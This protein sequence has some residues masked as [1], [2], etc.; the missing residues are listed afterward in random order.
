MSRTT[1]P[2]LGRLAPEVPPWRPQETT[3]R[4]P[5]RLRCVHRW[6]EAQ[7][8]RAPESIAVAVAVAGGGE[9]LT[10]SRLN[11]RANRLARRLRAMG[12]GPEILVGLYASRSAD[13][14]A[15]LLAVLKAG[16]AYVPLD[17]AY[18]EERIA[19]MLGD[20]G[21]AVL[22]TEDRL[23]DRVSGFDGP[24][25]SL[26]GDRESY[27]SLPSTDLTGGPVLDNLAYVIYT[28]G[29]TGR[30]KGAMIPHRG[31]A[32]YLAWC[33]RAYA[34][35]QGEGAPVHSS[36]SFDLTVTSLLAP[37]VAGRRVDLLDEDLGIEQLTAA[38]RSRRNYSLV[39]ITPAHLRSLGD[40]L[41]AD[42]LAGR[43]RAF[44]IGGEPL[45]AEHVAAWRRHA[46]GTE[47]VNE[48]GPTETVV[49]CCV[50]RVPPEGSI[51]GSLPIGRP[52]AGLRLYVLDRRL[53]PVPVGVAGELHIGGAGV[54]RGYLKRP[55]LTADRFLPDPFGREPGA[56]MYR[57]GDLARW[58]PDGNLEYLGRVDRQVKIRGH[59]VEPDEVEDALVRHPSVR[60]AAVEPR[61]YGPDD[62]RLFAYVTPTPDGPRPEPA[63]LRRFLKGTLPEPMIPSAFVVLDALPLTPNGKV[64]RA[65]LPAPAHDQRS[66]ETVFVAPRGPFE[67]LV[68]EVWSAVLGVKRV[69]ALD[70]FFDLGGHSLLATQVMS[71]IRDTFGFDVP[72]REL[73]ANPTVAALSTQIAERTR[74]G[75]G[76]DVTPPRPPGHDGPIPASHAQ[77]SLWFL[78]QLAPGEPTFHITLSSR[79][80]GPLDLEI[81][82]RAFAEI[83]RRHEV[84]RTTFR[85]DDGRP[86]QVI[87]EAMD[88]PLTTVDLRDLAPGAR[89]AEARRL[90]RGQAL[91][92]FDLERGPLARVLVLILGDDDHGIVLTMHHIV[93]DGWSLDVAARELVALYDAFGRGG[94]SPLEPLPIQYADYAVWQRTRLAGDDAAPLRD[95]WTRQ[96]AGVAPLELPTDRPRPPIRTSR[97][98]FHPLAIPAGLAGSI[99]ALG[100]R[101]G[102]TPFMVLLAAWQALLHRYSGQHDIVVGSPIA[103]R[104]RSELEGLIGYFV[105]M[106]AL[107]ADFSDDPSGLE[108]VGR[109]RDVALAAYEHQ[110]LPLELVIDAINPPRDPSRTPLFQVMFVLQ[111][112]RVPDLGGA[113]LTFEPLGDE[114]G[115][116]T[117]KFDLSLTLEESPEGFAGGIE[118]NTDLFDGETV[119]RMAARFLVLLRGLVESPDRRVSRLPLLSDDERRTTLAMGVGEPG[120]AADEFVAIHRHFE[121]Q[122]DRTP[123][124]RAV[125]SGG[126]C[127]TYRQLD[128]RANRLARELSARGI[129]RGDRVAIGMN[130]SVGLAVGLLGTLKAGAT[131][132]PLDPDYPGDRIA[133]M[134]E[135]AGAGLLLTQE[136]LAGRWPATR[137]DLLRIDADWP[138][139][140][141]QSSSRPVGD[142]NGDDSA[143]VIYT[144]GTTGEPRGVIVS[145]GGLVNH[146]L[147]AASLF[148]LSPDDR[149][150]QFSSLSF[151][152]AIE[153]MF[154][155]WISGAAVVF[156]DDS[157]L[158]GPLEFSQ[159]SARERITVLDLPTVYWHA[160][161]EG[162]ARLGERLPE[163]LRL[164]IVGG[165]R[166]SPR[167]FAEWRQIGGDRV[168]W[169]NTYGPTEGTVIASAFEPTD[170]QSEERA[171]PELPI[172]RPIP[173]ARIYLLD[174]RMEPVPA[175]LPGE[176]YIGGEGVALGYLGRP[177]ATASRFVP[178]P[179]GAVPGARLFRTGDRA[180]WRPDGQLEFVG[181]VDHQVKIRG[182]RVEP[183]EVESVLRRHPSVSDAVVAAREDAAG[184]RRLVAHVVPRPP[185]AIDPDDLRRWLQSTLPE[186]MV[187]SAFVAL[188][189][190]PLSPNGKLDR[191]ALPDPG[192]GSVAPACEYVAPRTPLEEELAR[193]WAEVLGHER[194]GIHDN[195]FD[196]GGH[197]LESVQL[198][199]RMT[200]ALGRPVT[201]RSVFQAPTI[202]AMAELLE[203]ISADAGERD[204]PS[205]AAEIARW[206]LDAAPPD[207]PEGVAIESRPFLPLF[208]SGTLAPVDAVALGYFPSVLLHELGL[209]RSAVT[210]DW[211]GGRPVITEVR[212]TAFGRIGAVLIPRFE[213]QLYADRDDLLDDLAA[214]VE[215]ARDI[216]ATTVSLTGLLPSASDYGRLLMDRLD[217]PG[218][219]RITTGHA[220]T[221]SAVVLAIRRAL[222]LAGREPAGEHVGFLG[223]GS[224]GAATLRLLLSCLPHPECLTLCDVYAKQ[225]T[226]EA[227]HR[228]LVDELGY[229]GEVRTLASGREVPDALYDASLIVGA[230]NVADILDVDR[231]RPGTIVVDDSAPHAFRSDHALRRLDDRADVLFNEGGML[232]APEPF[233]ITAYVPDDIEPW[234]RAGLTQ[235]VAGYNPRIITGC[236]LSG[237]LSARFP[238]LT[239]TV[240]LVDRQSTLDHYR[241]LEELGF[242]S[243]DLELDG[244]LID[245]TAIAAFRSRHGG[246][247]GARTRGHK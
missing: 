217:A 30:P 35:H 57:T 82:E 211:C 19:Y 8:K 2:G 58:R 188:D 71:R 134:L 157:A 108:L 96:L 214:A 128:E 170:A 205:G 79:V 161:V 219:P 208:A 203:Q 198:V 140:E 69:G 7:A 116:G 133:A 171:F 118:Y 184:N 120:A 127:L 117:A 179:F 225:D 147:A 101:A 39:K 3:H 59:R 95:Y 81:L 42:D 138:L 109:V 141:S 129:G 201:V 155:A 192:P 36:I 17:P 244:A 20:A 5:A 190:M 92:P 222:D 139:I 181:R 26:D 12:V 119:A 21:V 174:A 130:R 18:P 49:G 227:L 16:G 167:R 75:G 61:E 156:R 210:R 67:E 99:H 65:A 239:P 238:H 196:L 111:N 168:R 158:L 187:P 162:L 76:R 6:I 115:T 197:S 110:D 245:P 191:S 112:N 114:D 107:R 202:A 51:A 70:N 166:V 33:T 88:V 150:L 91:R 193:I 50:Y 218:L 106:L 4:A 243:P 56:R 123:D 149:V 23:R 9:A 163:P 98:T 77:Q 206:V 145:H 241:V 180:R 25:L 144:S 38:L 125:E 212:Q 178:D 103:N 194:V 173:G 66:F 80:R 172:G 236:V 235:L 41:G 104:N 148:G 78:E 176:L 143:Y 53:Q 10:Y 15:A 183:G 223:L 43:T 233:P 230:T 121:L 14:L 228:E 22:M 100:R 164:V 126:V 13:M 199:S 221:T 136:S 237:L 89:E 234:L 131:F 48:Y 63:E 175:G 124:A 246:G 146:G 200:G 74:T 24:I 189:A 209:D 73:F 83:L 137:A 132:V 40:Q 97:G 68:A 105:N 11:A 45:T 226:L 34:V 94:S 44:I 229:R 47:L 153:E 60:E 152:I 122:A 154:P 216:G 27:R 86:V 37:L 247:G 87:A 62:R 220:T 215:L 159:W 1:R 177:G 142:T 31:L 169:I 213:D 52:I 85:T 195:F 207:L 204:V 29:S 55:G 84:L 160:W 32:N 232:L 90:A 28:S 240:G 182:F 186:Y 72:L 113:G 54:G 64:D 242:R 93:G 151:D 135:D 46:P 231:L 185:A 165:E 224:V 102:A